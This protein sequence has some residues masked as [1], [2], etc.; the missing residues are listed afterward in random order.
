M[1]FPGTAKDSVAYDEPEVGNATPQAIQGSGSLDKPAGAEEEDQAYF[2]WSKRNGSYRPVGHTQD[3]IPAG[4]YE[5][6]NDNSG[7]FLSKVKFPSDNLLRLPGMPIE[8]ILNQIDTFWKREKMF[9]DTGLLH[10]RGILMYGPAGC[11]KTSDH[12]LA[13][14]R[15]CPARRHRHHGHELPLGRDGSWRHPPD[16]ATPPHPDDH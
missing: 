2:H 7:W 4:I 16:R 15:Y 10:K 6:D 5:I 8:F 1:A 3:K 13:L 12:P 9:K 14:R 11:G